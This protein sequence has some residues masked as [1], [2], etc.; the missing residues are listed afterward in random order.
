[1]K[2]LEL[3]LNSY[4]NQKT[5]TLSIEDVTNPSVQ[6]ILLKID[7]TDEQIGKLLKGRTIEIEEFKSYI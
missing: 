7:L 1:M 2:N 6:N 4:H 5:Q 3:R